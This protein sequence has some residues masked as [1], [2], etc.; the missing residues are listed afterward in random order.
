[1][2]KIRLLKIKLFKR[3]RLLAVEDMSSDF[4]IDEVP[5]IYNRNDSFSYYLPGFY[6][7]HLDWRNA[8]DAAVFDDERAVE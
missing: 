7:R 8:A 4:S 1:M 3:S 2:L 6:C 5:K